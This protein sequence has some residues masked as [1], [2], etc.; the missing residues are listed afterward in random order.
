MQSPISYVFREDPILPHH[1]FYWH[2]EGCGIPKELDFFI[3]QKEM[4]CI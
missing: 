4:G 2:C 3:F 1:L